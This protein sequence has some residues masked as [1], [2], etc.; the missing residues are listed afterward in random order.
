MT[1][2]EDFNNDLK[3]SGCQRVLY[4]L[5][6]SYKLGNLSTSWAAINFASTTLLHLWC[7]LGT[8]DQPELIQLSKLLNYIMKITSVNSWHLFLVKNRQKYKLTN[9]LTGW[10]TIAINRLTNYRIKN[11]NQL[12]S[13]KIN[14]VFDTEIRSSSAVHDEVRRCTWSWAKSIHLR[15]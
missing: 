8:P 9:R 13:Q 10:Q 4:L 7:D 15:S 3:E 6:V 11:Q 5:R 12:T 1:N 14:Q 2:E